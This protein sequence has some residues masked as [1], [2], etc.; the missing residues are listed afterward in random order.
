MKQ[1]YCILFD[2]KY[3]M[4][5]LYLLLINNWTSYDSHTKVKGIVKLQTNA[6]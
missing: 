1:F 3:N 6:Q 5:K 2:L 4:L